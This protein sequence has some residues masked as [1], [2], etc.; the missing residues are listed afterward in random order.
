MRNRFHRSS[1][2]LLIAAL[3]AGCYGAP[4][5]VRDPSAGAGRPAES[6]GVWQGET[7]EQ[8]LVERSADAINRMRSLPGLHSVNYYLQHAAG[9]LIFPSIIRAGLII[10]GEGGNG[11][12]VAR[13]PDGGWSAPAFYSLG[14]GSFG[15]QAGVQRAMLVLVF[16]NEN[17]FRSAIRSG[18]TL[19][20][21]LTVAAGPVGREERASSTTVL[22]D[23]YYFAHVN[24]LYASLSLNGRVISIRDS[25]N[26]KYYDKYA[27]P[28]AILLEGRYD[29]FPK[30]EV[31]RIA[32]SNAVP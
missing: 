23:V 22:P 4:R 11:V 13:R 9:V 3:L 5:E 25:L 17:A 28:Y 8:Q 32:L 20:V 10:G 21:D 2:L 1:V 18:V 24:G 15:L 19:G 26:R 7:S 30:T 31:L 27:E 16:T 6:T 29:H 14:G 12:M